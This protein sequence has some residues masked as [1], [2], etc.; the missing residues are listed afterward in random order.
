MYETELMPTLRKYRAGWLSSISVGQPC[1]WLKQGSS[2]ASL[3][4]TDFIVPSIWQIGVGAGGLAKTG[5]VQKM[6]SETTSAIFTNLFWFIC[7]VILLVVIDFFDLMI[8]NFSFPKIWFEPMFLTGSLA[9]FIAAAKPR[10][11]GLAPRRR[12]RRNAFE[13]F[14]EYST[15]KEFASDFCLPRFARRLNCKEFWAKKLVGD[16]VLGK[17]NFLIK[18]I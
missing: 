12:R 9:V 5:V 11:A 15:S 3:N 8:K 14:L 10:F 16:F 18:S 17:E 6:M 7:V 1:D 4:S 2:Y 13:L